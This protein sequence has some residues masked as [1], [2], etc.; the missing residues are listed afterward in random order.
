MPN[1]HIHNPP[2]KQD[3]DEADS[4][5]KG[6]LFGLCYFHAV[7]MERKMFGADVHV[8]V[9]G[10]V[11]F[12]Y[13]HPSSHVSASVLSPFTSPHSITAPTHP[14]TPPGPMGFNMLYP[15]SLGDLRDSAAC[16]AN[17]LEKSGGG[18]GGKI[19]W[20]DL[21]VRGLVGDGGGL[22]AWV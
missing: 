18:G 12:M 19:P 21:R 7:M 4:K 9:Y 15:F 16:L 14:P 5:T 13:T 11:V 22:Y 1:K 17:Y 3:I 10:G 8:Y 20:Q 2:N 6:I